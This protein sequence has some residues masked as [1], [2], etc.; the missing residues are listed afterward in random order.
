MRALREHET[1]PGHADHERD[2]QHGGHGRDRDRPRRP[3]EP[4]HRPALAALAAREGGG[5]AVPG[6]RVNDPGQTGHGHRPSRRQPAD[7]HR[8]QGEHQEI[9]EQP[10]SR[11]ERRQGPPPPAGGRAVAQQQGEQDQYRQRAQERPGERQQGHPE[12]QR[13]HRRHQQARAQG[14]D[15]ARGDQDC[16]PRPGLPAGPGQP[17][18]GGVEHTAGHHQAGQGQREA[19]PGP[20]EREQPSQI[21]EHGQRRERGH[22][23]REHARGRRDGVHRGGLRH[24]HGRG[25][26]DQARAAGEPPAAGSC[27]RSLPGAA[28]S[29][30]PAD[31]RQDRRSAPETRITLRGVS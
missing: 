23:G 4:A 14:E 13:D 2:G 7:H 17:G 31:R 16:G 25:H 5:H 18:Q 15:G 6:P 3:P 11:T 27:A 24:R 9:S 1:G 19:R 20:A 21:V 26:H 22:L 10:L 29:Q 28:A 12:R 8:G 30:Q